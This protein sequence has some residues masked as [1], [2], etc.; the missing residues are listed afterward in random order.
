M[1][2]GVCI[3]VGIERVSIRCCNNNQGI[4]LSNGCYSRHQRDGSQ[5]RSILQTMFPYELSGV[6]RKSAHAP[7]TTYTGDS[8]LPTR[9][10]ENG[11]VP[12]TRRNTAIS[13]IRAA[14]ATNRSNIRLP[15]GASADG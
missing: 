5:N 1:S 15:Q 6:R 12:G 2:I 3:L 9:Y 14:S 13:T 7:L 11:T 8:C 10:I 4:S